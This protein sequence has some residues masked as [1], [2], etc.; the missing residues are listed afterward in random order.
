MS[1]PTSPGPT[2]HQTGPGSDE[3][4]NESGRRAL[5][6]FFVLWTGQA[7]SLL[8]SQAVQFALIWWLTVH[9]GSATVLATAA[10]VGLLPQI[11][12]GPLIGA[13]V[14]RWNRKRIMLLADA[15]VATAS[16]LLAFLYLI[17]AASVT[18]V[19]S[20]LFVRGLGNAFHAPAMM[21]S[22]SLMVP[23]SHLTRIQGLNQ[24]LQGGQLIVSAPLGAL[25]V[26][27]LPMSGV[28]AVDVVT[29][30]FAIA[31]LVFIRVPQPERAAE[32]PGTGVASTWRD[33]RAGV[34]YL[35]TRSG[36][37]AL[38]GMSVVVNLCMVPAFSLLPLL[39]VEQQGGA[40][41][42]GW[43]S[44]LLGVGTI[45]GG[46]A[47]GIWGGFKKRI[48][49]TFCALV[50]AGVAT[51]L[52]GA[53]PTWRLGL[54]AMAAL[55]VMIPMVNGPILAVLQATVAPEFQGRVFTVYGSVAAIATPLGLAAAAPVA[56]VLGV[57]AWYA[58]G[59]VAC[60]LMGVA[61]FLVPA[62]AQIENPAEEPAAQ[63]A[64]S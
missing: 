35:W 56:D 15:A 64:G 44:S 54:G 32:S 17:D 28:M 25:L 63:A 20:L 19:L 37:A 42:L 14:D 52:L 9:T 11:V 57:R 59:G 21:A 46:I 16:A 24:S 47:L 12:L 10:L 51:A 40:M 55:G 22:T 39:V 3:V 30:L 4:P 31:P 7:L 48:Y 43:M 58:A 1:Q 61:G 33:V 23:K 60:V 27:T 38:L 2:P 49:T 5:T 34:R 8:G 41:Q 45:A 6:P 13:L 26:G 53:A 18:W 29:A 36:H 50:G 62:V